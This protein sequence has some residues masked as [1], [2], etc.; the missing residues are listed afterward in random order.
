[1]NFK[2]LFILSIVFLYTIFN[3]VYADLNSEIFETFNSIGNVSNPDIY[4]T[5]RRGV[6]AGGGV[7]VRHGVKNIDVL[8]FTSPDVKAGCSGIDLYGGSFSY[9]NKKEFIS[10]LRSVA[11]NAEGYAFQIA[12]SSMCEKC[13]QQIETLQKKVQELNQYFG[14][15][16]QLAQ[17]IVNDSLGSMNRKNDNNVSLIAQAKGLMDA[18]EANNSI[19]NNSI[20]QDIDSS[21]NQEAQNEVKKISGNILWNMLI[22]DPFFYNDKNLSQVILSIFGSIIIDKLSGN[23]VIKIV[24]GGLVN[25]ETLIDGGEVNI[26]KCD[27]LVLGGCLNVSVSKTKVKGFKFLI[28][29]VINGENGIISK[30]VSGDSF[31][32]SEIEI[33]NSLPPGYFS[34]IRTLAIQNINTAKMF[35]KHIS[36]IISMSYAERLFSSYIMQVNAVLKTSDSGFEKII[37]EN[38]QEVRENFKIDFQRLTEKCGSD[39]EVREYYNEL[40]KSHTPSKYSKW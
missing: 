18:F 34:M 30:I 3:C 40:L 32:D 27:T 22:Q 2:I 15:S 39:V 36:F 31:S 12:L 1:M 33:I 17:G 8:S 37:K 35:V 7:S 16:C 28:E 11:G 29:D 20:F 13:S 9:I 6:I 5:E 38:I 24:P 23:E 14:S 21:E 4:K 26:Y 19:G 25:I 10:F